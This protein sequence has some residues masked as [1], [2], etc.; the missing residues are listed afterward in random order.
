MAQSNKAPSS[1]PVS[2]I[3]SQFLAPHQLDLIVDRISS[4][5]LLITDINHKIMFKVK[6]CDSFFHEQRVLLDIDDQPIVVMRNKS[7]T[8]HDGWYVFRGDSESKSDMIFTKKKHCVIQ[9]LKSDVNVFLANKTSSKNVCDFKVAGSWSK[10]NCT[11]Y[12]GDTSTT[13]AQMCKMQSSENIIKF[14]NEKFKVT[15]SPNVDFAFVITI[16]AI[17]EAM[18]DSDKKSK[19]VVQVVGG[20]TN[21]VGIILL[22]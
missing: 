20:V 13:I 15:I 6:P 8:V 9:L 7:M 5:I 12:M 3:G 1:S 14:V 10:R 19:G 17:V 2:V 18:E 16:I 4:G 11:I 21:V 22:L